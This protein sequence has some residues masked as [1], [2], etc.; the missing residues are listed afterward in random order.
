MVAYSVVPFAEA[1]HVYHSL[2]DRLNRQPLQTAAL[3]ASETPPKLFAPDSH[4]QP[5]DSMPQAGGNVQ[6]QLLAK[7]S[8]ASG[9][10]HSSS[11][12]SNGGDM[13]R[14]AASRRALQAVTTIDPLPIA[15]GSQTATHVIPAPDG[16]IHLLNAKLRVG[17]DPARGGA[18]VHLSSP[19]M[20]P[21]EL[22]NTNLVNTW[23]RG[24]LIQQS[25]YGCY[26]GSC[27]NGKPWNWNPVQA[28]SWQNQAPLLL[29]ADVHEGVVTATVVP[30]NWGGQELLPDVVMTT[31]VQLLGDVVKVHFSMNYYGNITHMLRHQE[32]PAVFLTR[33]LDKL[34]MYT[35]QQPWTE[36]QIAYYWPGT[37]GQYYKPSEKW[38]AYVHNTTG[39]G[40]G[41]Y[42][43][44]SEQVVAY[45]VGKDGS[46]ALS[47]CAY[48]APLITAQ[49]EPHTE[50]AY[51]TYIAVGHETDIRR[52]FARVAASLL[53]QAVVRRHQH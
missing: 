16:T 24:R 2:Q 14:I 31:K 5:A 18:I 3:A 20:Q 36:D 22:A 10:M 41:S 45:R 43:P 17:I 50:F 53:P 27:W 25:Y 49:V 1:Y 19:A 21:K 15:E 40:V 37:S 13:A 34:A 33:Q 39:F 52:A 9:S 32:V 35:G 28:G 46:K 38:S 48:L 30:R 11:M 26:D 47:D 8:P 29:Q 7:H 42:T 23:D 44:V 12:V 51:D 4:K 6:Q